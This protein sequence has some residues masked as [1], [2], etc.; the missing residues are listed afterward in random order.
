LANSLPLKKIQ[1]ECILNGK[2]EG[3]INNYARRILV[4]LVVG[5][6]TVVDDDNLIVEI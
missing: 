2:N 4:Y 6:D 5:D 1:I 3:K